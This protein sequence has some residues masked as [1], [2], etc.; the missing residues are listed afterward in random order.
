M[1]GIW[2]NKNTFLDFA[3]ARPQTAEL[4]N[5][6]AS[7]SAAWDWTGVLGLLPDLDPVLAKRGE[8]AE[9]L[10]ELT[11]DSHVTA[12]IQTRKLGTLKREFKWEAGALPGKKATPQAEKLRDDLVADLERV[13]LYDLVSEILDAPMY[14]YTPIEILWEPDSSRLR[15]KDLRGLPHRWF[16]FDENNQPRFISIDNPWDGQEL[17][18]GKFVFARHFPKYDNPYGLRLLSRCFWPVTFKKGG[19]KFW[20]TFAEKFGMPF[21]FGRY[22]PGAEPDEQA[23]LLSDLV[24]MVR[25]AVA[26]G[27]DGTSV[28]LINQGSGSKGSSDMF[29][30]LISVMNAEISKVIVGQTASAEGTPGK[31]GNEDLQ[32]DVLEDIQD[33][34]QKLVKKVM[35]EIAGIYGRVNAPGVPLPQFDWFEDEE[36]QTEFAERDGKL[37][38]T[39]VT[40]TKKYYMRRYN[41]AEDE[42]EVEEEKEETQP[43]PGKKKKESEFA[44]EV[45]A[46]SD[47]DEMIAALTAAE[48]DP[49]VSGWADKVAALV[50]E[51][52]SLEE[53]RDSL[54]DLYTLMDDRP[55]AN[56]IGVGLIGADLIGRHEINESLSP[57]FSESEF[58]EGISTEL[59]NLDT[60]GKPFREAVVFFRDKV[61]LPTEHWYTLQR[62]MHARAFTI[63]GAMKGEML[64]DFRQAV[65]RAISKGTT[66][67][68]FRKDFDAIVARHGWSYHGSRNWRSKLIYNTNIQTAY[69]AG[70]MK[71]LREITD[72]AP[73]WE[74]ATMRD[75]RVREVHRRWE[76][77]ILR[78]DDPWWDTHYPPNG[79]NCRCRVWPRTERDMEKRG[80]QLDTAPE[81]GTYDWIN[82]A[83]GEVV[84][85]PNGID[86]GWDYN[87]G[88]G[89]WG[90]RL[91][92]KAMAAWRQ[93]KDKWEV[94]TPGDHT[95]YNRPDVIPLDQPK[96][97]PGK[98]AANEAEMEAA[99]NKAIGGPE[100]VFHFQG[101]EFSYPVLVNAKSLSSHL[102]L[103]RSVWIPLLEEVMADPF[104][105]WMT[106]EKHA[107]SGQ[108]VLRQR[109]IK[110]VDL[111]GSRGL[112]AVSN[113]S[114]GVME[115]WTFIPTKDLRYANNQRAG[116]LVW[117]RK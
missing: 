91:S 5:E 46:G 25:D 11:G 58:A 61:N 44:E 8:G 54:I 23:K 4:V 62:E 66:L 32:G 82:K 63:A 87:V 99:I 64:S 6:I 69:Q 83:T 73:Y 2:V 27:P 35:E 24:S 42:F 75:S 39:G 71:Q 10:D 72:V 97:R 117:A 59:L 86:P 38:D 81:D 40:F 3:E 31:L 70:R 89:A 13:D 49:Y 113:S 43:E 103:E 95:T 18:S 34:D 114:N 9:I 94:L 109:I 105:V 76:G 112:L 85:V 50:M 84:K 115:A 14:G 60:T 29:D 52:S 92:D 65:D 110:A 108:V 102:A 98:K 57:A 106:F 100:R 68:Q 17:P 53:I 116:Q 20:M 77:M 15:I 45:E 1:S 37:K 21:L 36:P 41:L 22:R 67:P 47:L 74:Y 28:E 111:G 33:G 12:E 55:L 78:H 16:G 93:S 107:A 7:R 90:Q 51:A 101:G 19:V 48:A 79:W 88:K 26:I 104:E 30:R 56:A 96:A 80:R